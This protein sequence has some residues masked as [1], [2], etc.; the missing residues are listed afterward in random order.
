MKSSRNWR[1][2]A[3]CSD[4]KNPQYWLSYD[5]NHIRYAKEG[6]K[7]CPVKMECFS[8]AIANEMYTGVNAGISEWDYLNKT[9]QKAKKLDESNWRRTAA[10]FRKLL[11]E[12]Q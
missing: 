10:A 3:V 9:W 1:E 4:D 11:Q 12:I 5:I 7:R 8:S 6:C 2:I